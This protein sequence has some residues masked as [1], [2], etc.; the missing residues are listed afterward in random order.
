MAKHDRESHPFCVVGAGITGLTLAFLLRQAGRRVV[1]L[2]AG[3]APGGVIASKRMDGFLFEHGP[4]STLL[5]GSRILDVVRAAGLEGDL[6][7]AREEAKKRYIVRDGRLRALPA[8]PTAFLCSNLLSRRARVRVLREVL[9][10]RGGSEEESVA[11]FV[12]RRLG[13]EFLDYVINPFVAGVY[14]GDPEVLNLKAAFPKLYALEKTYGGL[15]RGLIGKNLG[16]KGTASPMPGGGLF[17][18]REGMQALP[19]ALA[20]RLGS[21]YRPSTVVSGVET[22]PGGYRIYAGG[23]T[24]DAER[25]ILT[26]P[27]YQAGRLLAGLSPDAAKTLQAVP[28]APVA[29]VFYGFRREQVAHPLDGFGFLVPAREQQ[30]VL[31]T[32]WNTSLFDG[33]APAGHVALTSFVGGLRQPGAVALPDEA[34]HRRVLAALADLIG[35]SGAPVIAGIRRCERAIP[36][37]T[38]RHAAV[39]NAVETVESAFPGLHMAGSYRGGVSVGDCILNACDLAENL[40]ATPVVAETG[41]DTAVG[42]T[43]HA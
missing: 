41:E 9:I 30:P 5:K 8:T 27:A 26:C 35:V 3:D 15:F 40:L 17:S 31:G 36:Q 28:Y 43:F 34:L 33:R 20:G 4:N 21:A 16:R 1:L 2:D 6:I 32:L 42:E 10:P 13:P 18:F 11:A 39:I 23:T 19:R 7:Y 22:R 14:A 24:I 29:V 38:H 12:R 37:Y 25:L